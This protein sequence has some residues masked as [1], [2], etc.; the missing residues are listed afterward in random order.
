MTEGHNP[1]LAGIPSPLQCAIT[2]AG[3]SLWRIR[4]GHH[5]YLGELR[6]RGESYSRGTCS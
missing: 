6:V 3:R 5:E 2:A 1:I 4:K